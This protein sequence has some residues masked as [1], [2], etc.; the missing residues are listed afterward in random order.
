MTVEQFRSEV[1]RRRSFHWLWFIPGCLLIYPLRDL[2]NFLPR[3]WFTFEP[4][5]FFGLV[6]WF[7]VWLW[8]GHHQTS[9]KCPYC[10]NRAFGPRPF[11]STRGLKCVACGTALF[12]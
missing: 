11:V 2:F 12:G 1:K 10:G 4:G 5:D 9:A 3:R 8:L 6:V 7:A